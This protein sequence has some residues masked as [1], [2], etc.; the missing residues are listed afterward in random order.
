[1]PHKPLTEEFGKPMAAD[2]TLTS[3]RVFDAEYGRY[4]DPVV[5]VATMSKLPV[6]SLPQVPHPAPFEIKGDTK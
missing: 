1:M 2:G 5:K 4:D 3:D 6:V